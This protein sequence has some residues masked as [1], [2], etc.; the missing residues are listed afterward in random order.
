M[1]NMPKWLAATTSDKSVTSEVTPPTSFLRNT[2]YV[3]TKN[4][5]VA[6]IEARRED[7]IAIDAAQDGSIRAT[8]HFRETLQSKLSFLCA[9]RRRRYPDRSGQ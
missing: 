9:R 1:E 2:I 4:C 3:T 8:K 5:T 7:T 6:A